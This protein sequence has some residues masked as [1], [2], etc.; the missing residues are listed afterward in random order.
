MVASIWR[1]AATSRY[2]LAAFATAIVSGLAPDGEDDA[3]GGGRLS[4]ERS[5]EV[6]ERLR[7]LEVARQRAEA[8]SRDYHVR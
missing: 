3:A 5:A 1:M 6:A 2:P 4:D 8:R 7:A